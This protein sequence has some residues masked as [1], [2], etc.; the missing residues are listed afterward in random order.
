MPNV[1]IVGDTMRTPELRHEV[2]LGIPDP[3]FYAELDG[4]RVVAIS[5]M[6]AARGGGLGP[7]LGVP[8]TEECGADEIRRSGLDIHTA[9]TELAVRIARGLGI[10]EATVPRNFPLGIGDALRGAGIGL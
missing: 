7:G 2:P 3:F 10:D 9:A 1:L 4:R 8:S 6:E 5:A